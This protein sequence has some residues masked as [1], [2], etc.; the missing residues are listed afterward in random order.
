MHGKSTL[1]YQQQFTKKKTQGVVKK[2]G[3]VFAVQKSVEY[4][5]LFRAKKPVFQNTVLV[6]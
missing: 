2:T 4:V 3:E 5:C 6:I 1:N